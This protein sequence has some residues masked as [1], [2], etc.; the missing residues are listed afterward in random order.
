MTGSAPVPAA[1]LE[2]AH[3]IGALHRTGQKVLE[4]LESGIMRACHEIREAIPDGERRAAFIAAHTPLEPVRADALALAWEGAREARSLRTLSAPEAEGRL[5]LIEEFVRT[6]GDADRAADALGSIPEDKL[7]A[8][9][10]TRP[11]RARARAI[12]RMTEQSVPGSAPAAAPRLESDR[13]VIQWR[14]LAHQVNAALAQLEEQLSAAG[15]RPIAAADRIC[16]W[17]DN[18]SVRLDSLLDLAMRR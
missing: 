15:D 17:G 4:M 18:V 16:E 9:V 2:A 6:V 3:R 14:P 12:R 13:A 11:P 1:A 10:M 8:E 7:L 5:G